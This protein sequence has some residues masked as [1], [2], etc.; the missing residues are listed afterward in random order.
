VVPLIWSEV[1]SSSG[2]VT[3][4]MVKVTTLHFRGIGKLEL[5]PSLKDEFSLLDD[6]SRMACIDGNPLQAMPTNTAPKSFPSSDS[7]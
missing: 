2:V 1:C 4:G 3:M 7:L 5:P 6:T